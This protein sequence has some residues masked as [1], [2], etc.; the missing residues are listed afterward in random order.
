MSRRELVVASLGPGNLRI[1]VTW[2]LRSIN[3]GCASVT[4][5]SQIS[6]SLAIIEC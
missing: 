2:A 4:S 6:G 3:R 5:H 1:K